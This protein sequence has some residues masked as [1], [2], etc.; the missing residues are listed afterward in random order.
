MNDGHLHLSE[1]FERLVI[2][3]GDEIVIGSENHAAGVVVVTLHERF[4]VVREDI[5]ET[6]IDISSVESR[7]VG[8]VDGVI[9]DSESVFNNRACAAVAPSGFAHHI[10]AHNLIGFFTFGYSFVV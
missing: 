6:A 5:I 4:F 10:E 1:H 7:A 9:V 2:H 8:I 3:F